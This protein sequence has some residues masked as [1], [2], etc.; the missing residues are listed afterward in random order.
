M[1]FSAVLI[2]AVMRSNRGGVN[3][4]VARVYLYCLVTVDAVQAK[5]SVCVTDHSVS[6]QSKSPQP[7]LCVSKSCPEF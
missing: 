7:P 4:A 5:F 2:V 3:A 6:S 1:F